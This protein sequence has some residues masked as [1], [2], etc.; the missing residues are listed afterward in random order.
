MRRLLCWPA[1]AAAPPAPGEG[2]DVRA[3]SEP[4]S[5]PGR[6]APVSRSALADGGRQR[7]PVALLSL[8]AHAPLTAPPACC[9]PQPSRRAPCTTVR[10]HGQAAAL[11]AAPHQRR[12]LQEPHRDRTDGG[13][14]CRRGYRPGLPF[15]PLGSPRPSCRRVAPISLPSPARRWSSHAGRRWRKLRSGANRE[16]RWT[17]GRCSTGGGSSP[18]RRCGGRQ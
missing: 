3:R 18:S 6:P 1:L 12:E 15:R 17:T 10:R 5:L 16:K 9:C 4:A 8:S 7:R 2:W 14:F 13:P 11:Y